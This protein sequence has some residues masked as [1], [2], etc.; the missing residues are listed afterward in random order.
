MEKL[1]RIGKGPNG[2]IVCKIRFVDGNLSIIGVEGPRHNGTA[3]G[4]CGQIVTHDWDIADYAPGWSPDQVV[5]FREVWRAW[6]LNNLRPG[7]AH[8]TGPEW[9]PREVEVITYRLSAYGCALRL[10]AI[11]EAKRAAIAGEVAHLSDTGRAM[12]TGACE[13]RYSAPDADDSLSGLFEVKERKLV[14]TE[15][16]PE[17]QH[18]SGFL[19]KACPV[20]GYKY[21][22]KWLREEVPAEVVDFLQSLPDSDVIPAW[23]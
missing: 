12:L 3:R 19:S 16:L 21:G 4:G 7:C 20:C 18:P 15:F 13:E 1:V 23:M 6:H 10:A 14:S 8:Q 22:S 5:K 2:H 11:K 9:T 17:S